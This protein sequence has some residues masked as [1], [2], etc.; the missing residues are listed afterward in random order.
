M[1]LDNVSDDFIQTVEDNLNNRPRKS[2]GFLTPLE[3]KSR[4]E[5]VTLHC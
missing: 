5:C 3:V 4:N 2:L 1:R